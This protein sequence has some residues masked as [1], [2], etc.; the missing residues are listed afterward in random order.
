MR[1]PAMRDTI[2]VSLLCFF[3]FMPS[4]HVSAEGFVA[5]S[6]REAQNRARLGSHSTELQTL[7][8]ITRLVGAVYD[9]EGKD[10]VLVGRAVDGLPECLLD[11]LVVALRSRLLLGEWPAVSIDPTDKT[12]ITGRQAV[13]FHGGLAGTK[14]GSDFLLCDVILKNYSLGLLHTVPHVKTYKELAAESVCQ[15]IEDTGAEVRHFRWLSSEDTAKVCERLHGRP[16]TGEDACQLQFWFYC[17][18]PFHV[19]CREGVFSIEELKLTVKLRVA[20]HGETGASGSESANL[21]IAGKAFAEQFGGHLSEV[22]VAYPVLKRLK[23]LFDLVAVSEGIR[24]AE[25]C[26]DLGYFLKEYRTVTTPTS[27]NHELVDL[28]GTADISDGSHQLIRISGGIRFETELKWLNDG[29]VAPLREIVLETRP[30]P[31]ALSWP[32]PLEGWRMPNATDL[33]PKDQARGLVTREGGSQMTSVKG[34]TF[35]IQSVVLAPESSLIENVRKRFSGFPPL[36]PSAPPL[37]GVSMRMEVDSGSYREDDSGRL[38]GL[39]E[40]LLHDREQKDDATWPVA[41]G[42]EE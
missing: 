15:K 39:R 24:S 19:K 42:E 12:P 6:L 35:N 14:F 9:V 13:T 18:Q 31:H 21:V 30:E 8:G 29:D 26:A 7:G 33:P 25:S 41:E 40:K 27:S 37:K 11:D 28:F 5:F 36:P 34:C 10:I 16:V 23:T 1:A 3:L 20:G 38:N 17:C 4:S 22:E 32:L 2:R